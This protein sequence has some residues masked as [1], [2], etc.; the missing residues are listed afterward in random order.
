MRCTHS[1]FYFNPKFFILGIIFLHCSYNCS[2]FILS[3][4]FKGSYLYPYKSQNICLSFLFLVVPKKI[5]ERYK[6]FHLPWNNREKIFSTSRQMHQI[7]IFKTL[8]TSCW[9]AVNSSLGRGQNQIINLSEVSLKE[10]TEVDLLKM[11]R[12]STDPRRTDNWH[13]GQSTREKQVKAHS[14]R[15]YLPAYYPLQKTNSW[16]KTFPQKTQAQV[17][18][19]VNSTKHLRE[20]WHQFYTNSPRKIKGNTL[21]YTLW[22]QYCPNSI[23][24]QRKDLK[25]NYRSVSPMNVDVKLQTKY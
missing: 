10:G 4:L 6:F 5:L 15:N 3:I 14:R 19:L 22:D 18:L 2:A 8:D 21:K 12:Q 11:S 16:L 7:M 23:I 24:R 13:K 9:N 17:T 20:R 1:G 25:I